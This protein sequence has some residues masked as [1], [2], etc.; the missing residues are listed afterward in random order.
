MKKLKRQTAKPRMR[1]CHV[2]SHTGNV[3]NETADKLAKLAIAD[4]NMGSD[5]ALRRAATIFDRERRDDRS[6]RV[7]VPTGQYQR[8]YQSCSGDL[9]VHDHG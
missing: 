6:I 9:S 2:L 8:R 4:G 7:P 3:G 1:I 5:K